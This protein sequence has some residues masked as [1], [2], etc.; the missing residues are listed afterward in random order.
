MKRQ[1]GNTSRLMPKR[2]VQVDVVVESKSELKHHVR[3]TLLCL[4]GLA[5]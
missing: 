5:I 1:R 2:Y 3:I 4:E